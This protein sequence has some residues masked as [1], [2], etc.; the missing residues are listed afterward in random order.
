[1]L[2]YLAVLFYGTLGLFLAGFFLMAFL[3]ILDTQALSTLVSM[4]AASGHL[5]AAL[6]ALAGIFLVV[7]FIFFRSFAGTRQ[8]EKV[9]AFDNPDGR[10]SVSLSALEE[11]VKRLTGRLTEIKEARSTMTVSKK[12]LKVRLKLVMASDASI[13]EVTSR[14]QDIVKKKIQDTIGMDENVLVEIHVGKILQDYAPEA[15]KIDKGRRSEG[16]NT[17]TPVPCQGYRA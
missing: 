14:I 7:N 2:R 3:G 9:I 5:Q 11:L 17:E 12:G 6:G 15:P 13:P 1:M 16:S 4:V 8:R 10:V